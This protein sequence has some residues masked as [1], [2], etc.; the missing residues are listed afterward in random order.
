MSTNAKAIG[1]LE[2]NIDGFDK[3]LKAA[4]N[5]M[6]T[7][8]A[9]F[10]A[11]KIGEFFKDGIK[12]AIS[13]GK[14]MQVAGH[15]MGGMD[16]GKLLLVQKAL[17]NAGMGAE[18]ARGHINDFIRE[19]R[20]ISEIFTSSDEFVKAIKN[21]SADY[22]TQA[23]VL[24]Q[25]GSKLQTV[26]NTMQAISSQIRTFF[27]ELVSK[28]IGPLQ[29]VLDYMDS[30]DFVKIADGMGDAINEAVTFLIGTFQ[31]GN[32]WQLAKLG[33][34]VAFEEA[35]N[36]LVGGVKYLIDG[37]GMFGARVKQTTEYLQ[38]VIPLVFKAAVEA[39][40]NPK[41][42]S[43]FRSLFEGIGNLLKAILQRSI[44]EIN[45]LMGQSGAAKERR[46]AADQYERNAGMSFNQ[47]GRSFDAIPWED[48]AKKL[49]D[50]IE[51]ANEKAEAAF[52]AAF[53]KG[54]P[55]EFKAADLFPGLSEELKEL[56]RLSGINFKTGQQMIAES[57]KG[58]EAPKTNAFLSSTGRF[59][60][61][62]SLQKVGGG[63]GFL[64]V[65]RS[66]LEK[67]AME[68]TKTAKAQLEVTKASDGKLQQVITN[69]RPGPLGR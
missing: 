30:K 3:A 63:G 14:E 8:A 34:K 4:K 33:M 52:K 36:Y 18:E 54:G 64:N 46:E 39:I 11:Y 40:T 31:N 68:Q 5:L 27:M 7:F 2:L 60:I 44:A 9:G 59:V 37:A 61:A 41:I 19:G 29:V 35:V 47:A 42:V 49:A 38:V 26:W 12:D 28:F 32:I 53:P 10:S 57:G 45:D 22:G 51:K 20:N 48:I 16:P 67:N 23:K 62:D 69:T 1:Y 17:E 56:L 21:A 55:N 15:M 13:F 50:S 25:Q 24:S 66:L 65:G 6:V 58:H 43:F